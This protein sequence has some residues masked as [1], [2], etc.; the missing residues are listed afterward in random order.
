MGDV[1]LGL[2]A[3]ASVAD[4]AGLRV[5]NEAVR[6]ALA[7]AEAEVLRLGEAFEEL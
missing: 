5:E 6:A 3:C 4:V 2:H 1:Q 7:G